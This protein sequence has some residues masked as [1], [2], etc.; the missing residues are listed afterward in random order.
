MLRKLL[1]AATFLTLTTGAAYATTV[2]GTAT[3]K[4][5]GPLHNAVSFSAAGPVNFSTNLTAGGAGVT[6]D[7]FIITETYDGSG[8]SATDKVEADFSFTAPPGGGTVSGSGTGSQTFFGLVNNGSL[9]WTSGDVTFA[10]GAVIG[11]SLADVASSSGLTNT[12]V[13]SDAATLTLIKDPT[14][15]VPEP[16][17]L[18]LLGT[19]LLGLGLAMRRRPAA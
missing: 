15:A 13:F 18:A 5:D 4:D 14:T 7:P 2:S 10:D 11:I 9:T 12:Q 19:G 1:V 3:F 6:I 8:K 17:S 16:G